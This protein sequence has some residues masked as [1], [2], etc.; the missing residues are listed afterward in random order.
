MATAFETLIGIFEEDGLRHRVIPDR[1][2]VEAGFRGEAGRYL[3]HFHVDEG[4]GVFQIFVMLPC[5]IPEG[6]R[7]AVAEAIC[8]ANFGMKVGNFELD[9]DDGEVRFHVG[10]CFPEGTLDPHVVR[11]LLGTALHVADRYLPALMSVVYGN[12]LP[13]D[14]IEYVEGA[15][16]V[17]DCSE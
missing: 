8:R 17:V 6:C 1:H 13:K 4:E 7:L 5:F 12:E 9:C 10:N 16:R 15:A 2:L 11:R 14:A 3:L